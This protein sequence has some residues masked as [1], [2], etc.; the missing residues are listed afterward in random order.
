VL[1]DKN[2]LVK[3]E[4]KQTREN[5]FSKGQSR[6]RASPLTKVYGLVKISILKQGWL[7]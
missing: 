6:F 5:F 2:D 4:Y 3:P 7:N 1:A